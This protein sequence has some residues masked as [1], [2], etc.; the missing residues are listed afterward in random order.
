MLASLANRVSAKHPVHY[1]PL[2]TLRRNVVGA[3]EITSDQTRM[4]KL[5]PGGHLRPIELFDPVF[6]TN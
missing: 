5:R 6:R 2:L 1:C 3:V 4:A